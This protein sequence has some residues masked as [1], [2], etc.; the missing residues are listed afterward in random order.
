MWSFVPTAAVPFGLLQPL[1]EF[2]LTHAQAVSP[3]VLVQ[4]LLVPTLPFGAE[5][6]LLQYNGTRLLRIACAA[7]G[8]ALMMRSWLSYR[9]IR[10]CCFISHTHANTQQHRNTRR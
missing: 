6:I 9:V 4:M 5:I 10:E 7:V 3:G 2:A 8:C 1:H